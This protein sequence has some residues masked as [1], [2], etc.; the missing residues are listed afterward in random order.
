MKNSRD[1]FYFFSLNISATCTYYHF[2]ST[3][4]DVTPKEIF[5]LGQC[6]SMLARERG[7]ILRKNSAFAGYSMLVTTV[8]A[9]HA[10][11]YRKVK[12][13]N[14]WNNIGVKDEFLGIENRLHRRRRPRGPTDK[15][16]D[17]ESGD[18][19]FDSWCGRSFIFC[20]L[21]CNE[22]DSFKSSS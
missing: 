19:R 18:S 22:T 7:R 3:W 20:V 8:I 16:S 1:F 2:K 4:N 11:L 15:A 9:W 17:Y 12:Y 13:I 21:Y 14:H 10:I 6:W 5:F